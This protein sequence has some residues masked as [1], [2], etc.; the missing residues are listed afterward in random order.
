[1]FTFCAAIFQ[2]SPGGR[3][4]PENR[5]IRYLKIYL[6]FLKK[7][8]GQIIHR[9][10]L[11]DKKNIQNNYQTDKTENRSELFKI[12]KTTFKVRILR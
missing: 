10:Q 12:V 7:N 2:Q 9:S 4:N 8:Q 6:D 11:F 1:M 5:N 3:I